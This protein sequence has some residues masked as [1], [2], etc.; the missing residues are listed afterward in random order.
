M[1]R[2]VLSLERNIGKEDEFRVLRPIAIQ[3]LLEMMGSIVRLSS[4]ARLRTL[5]I[6]SDINQTK[7]PNISSKVF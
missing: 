4:L 6:D 7:D 2:C 1:K 3:K 5:S